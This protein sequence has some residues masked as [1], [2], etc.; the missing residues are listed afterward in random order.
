MK[1][2]HSCT[3]TKKKHQNKGN[4]LVS[5]QLIVCMPMIAPT[6]LYKATL[7]RLSSQ[8]HCLEVSSV[9]FSN[10]AR[11]HLEAHAIESAV[12][13]RCL[14]VQATEQCTHSTNFADHQCLAVQAYHLW[15]YASGVKRASV[16]KRRLCFIMDSFAGL[17]CLS[18]YSHLRELQIPNTTC[19]I[20]I[21]YMS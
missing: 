16:S 2:G 20:N 19:C 7:Q 9:H 11:L 1:L 10:D 12:L 14:A 18:V 5:L 15:A 8:A 17:T 13:R 3:S 4:R 21:S 6:S